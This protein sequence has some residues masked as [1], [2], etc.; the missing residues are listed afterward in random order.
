MAFFLPKRNNIKGVRANVFQNSIN[1]DHPNARPKQN[2]TVKIKT[3]LTC[4]RVINRLETR[5]NRHVWLLWKIGKRSS[6]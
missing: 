2:I 5:F 6:H 4:M 1:K 3:T